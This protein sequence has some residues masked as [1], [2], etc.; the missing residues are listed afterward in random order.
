MGKILTNAYIIIFILICIMFVYS[1]ISLYLMKKPDSIITIYNKTKGRVNLDI[2][3][4]SRIQF[5]VMCI[6]LGLFIIEMMLLIFIKFI[7]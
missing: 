1:L 3:K 4:L 2:K 7:I 6:V 5:I